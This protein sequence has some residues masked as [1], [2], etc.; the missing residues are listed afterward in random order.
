MLS[1]HK[2]HVWRVLLEMSPLTCHTA[3]TSFSG[4]TCSHWLERELKA[5]IGLVYFR[6]LYGMNHHNIELLFK[7]GIGPDIFGATMSQRRMRFLLAHITFDD[8]S[9]RKDRW[10]SDR[11]AAGRDIYEMFNK[12]C[13]KYVTPSEYLAIDGILYP[14]R[15]QIAFRQY[16]PKKPHKYW[17]LL[18]SINDSRFPFT[19]KAAPYAGKLENG[20]GPRYICTTEDYVK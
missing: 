15:H 10:P 16:N 17:L 18:K 19:Y 11:F 13:S 4:M 9:T 2:Y 7:S 12:N 1:L 8:K 14:K 5:F 6:G 3:I 20:D